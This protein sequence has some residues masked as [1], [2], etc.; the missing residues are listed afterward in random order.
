MIYLGDLRDLLT[1]DEVAA[2]LGMRRDSVLRAIK[3]GRLNSVRLGKRTIT[4]RKQDLAAY[5]ARHG[6]KKPPADPPRQ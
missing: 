5:I 2:A 1:L 4:V 6:T 3:E